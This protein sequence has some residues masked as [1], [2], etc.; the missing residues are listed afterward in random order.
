MPSLLERWNRYS[1]VLHFIIAFLGVIA[2]RDSDAVA[3]H[4]RL[5]L[6]AETASQ[7]LVTLR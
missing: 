4:R 2:V 7:D 1:I 3:T 6:K 5:E